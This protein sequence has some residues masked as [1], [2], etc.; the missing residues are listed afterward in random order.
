MKTYRARRWLLSLTTLALGL[1]LTA[2]WWLG[3]NA[4]QPVGLLTGWLLLALLLGLAFFNAR[5]KLPFFPLLS[6]ST[7]LQIHI[8]AGWFSVLVFLLHTGARLPGALLEFLLW[9]GFVL[10]AVSGAFGLWLSRWLPPRLARSGESLVYERIPVLRRR[11]ETEAKVLVRQAETETKSTTLADFYL[12]LLAPYFAHRPA[13]L[14]PLAGD[15]AEHHHVTR[16]LAALRRFLNERE[17]AI[18]DQLGELLEAKRNLD[19]QL[20]GQRLL[21]LWLF[22]HI[23]LTYGLLVL[24]GAHVWLVLHY[25]HRL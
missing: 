8:Y 6:A 16:E 24:V 2:A 9:L 25:S 21:K 1:A 11:L 18:V 4:L 3:R 14:A 12:R 20:A 7:W 19:I 22:A 15:D 13:L 23:P 17:M 5:K 10:V